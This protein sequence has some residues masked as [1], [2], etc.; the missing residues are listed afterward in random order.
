M[1][2]N[3]SYVNVNKFSFAV[4]LQTEECLAWIT[5]NDI[6]N[7]IHRIPI[8]YLLVNLAAA[9]VIYSIF[10]VPTLILKHTSAHPVG[11]TGR[12]LC[13]LLT[14]GNFAWIGAASAVVTLVAIAMERYY[15]VIY[16]HGN[17]G[18]LT[19]RRLKVCHSN[20][21]LAKIVEF[22]RRPLV[23]RNIISSL[24]VAALKSISSGFCSQV[25]NRSYQNEAIFCYT[26]KASYMLYI[27][28]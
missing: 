11:L 2:V 1:R 15:A 14:G 6:D 12:V 28:F 27:S 5:S 23:M 18:K 24:G 4:S 22:Q 9:D 17:K 19:T 7:L 10:L 25:Q 20:N 21:K 26:I 3:S 8:N 13:G 16:P